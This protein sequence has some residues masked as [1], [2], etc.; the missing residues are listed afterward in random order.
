MTPEQISILFVSISTLVSPLILA[1]SSC[2]KRIQKSKCFGN[3][4]TFEK[5]KIN[6]TTV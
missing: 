3:E 2:I 6:E 4:L 5:Q 1:F